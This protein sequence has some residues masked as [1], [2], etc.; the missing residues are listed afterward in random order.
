MSTNDAQPGYAY[1]TIVPSVYYTHPKAAL[2][3]LERAFGFETRMI[4]EGPDGDE[5]QIHCE[6]TFGSGVIFV[7]GEWNPSVKSPSSVGGANTQGIHVRFDGD[8]DA[9]CAQ[10][11]AAGARITREPEDQF[12][13]DRTYSA[14]DL[15][16][17]S[18]SFAKPIQQ[19]SLNDMALAGGVEIKTSL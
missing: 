13:G 12:Y 8:L 10:A 18:W 1:P 4:I 3:W 17:H 11:R 6:M 5:S 16:G 15:E 14:V 7:G 19:L 2:A 9:H